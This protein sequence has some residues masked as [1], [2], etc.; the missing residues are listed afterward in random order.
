MI[1]DK[2][3]E[4]KAKLQTDQKIHLVNDLPLKR[5]IYMTNM[6]KTTV[7]TTLIAL[8]FNFI[9]TGFHSRPIDHNQ[10][11]L[12]IVAFLIA[13]M[14]IFIIDYFHEQFEKMQMASISHNY[15]I[16]RDQLNKEIREE[17]LNILQEEE[18]SK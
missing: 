6:V 10:I 12:G 14:T 15:N 9:F 1:F 7:S 11:L 8:A 16:S 13:I 4:I 18:E 2:D 5:D 17:L 3:K